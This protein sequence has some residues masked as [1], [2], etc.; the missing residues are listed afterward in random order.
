MN[1]EEEQIVD[2]PKC[3]RCKGLL[4]QVFVSPV[5]FAIPSELLSCFKCGRKYK[6][7]QI[8]G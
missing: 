5:N 3:L 2:Y 8:E 6:L 7:K 4:E 1:K